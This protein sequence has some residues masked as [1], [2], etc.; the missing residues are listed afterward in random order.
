M[1][2][3][4]IYCWTLKFVWNILL[5]DS[6]MLNDKLY[7]TTHMR[8]AVRSS[9]QHNFQFIILWK[10]FIRYSFITCQIL[11]YDFCYKR[12]KLSSFDKL[13]LICW[14]A[15]YSSNSTR[16]F[17]CSFNLNSHDLSGMDW[18]VDIYIFNGGPFYRKTMVGV[19]GYY[20]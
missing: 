6:C 18:I 10:Y 1:P 19:M 20:F 14:S 2:I 9:K 8:I 7:L 15:V 16:I 3:A 17:K 12:L 4:R 5:N 11:M 13:T